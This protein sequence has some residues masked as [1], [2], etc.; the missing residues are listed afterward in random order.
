MIKRRISKEMADHGPEWDEAL[1]D[2]A[3]SIN[4]QQQSSTKY[5]PFFLMFGRE[6]KTLMEVSKCIFSGTERYT[7][8]SMSFMLLKRQL[9][10]HVM[11]IK[12]ELVLK[13][14]GLQTFL[15]S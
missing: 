9:N 15:G 14:W 4:S 3:F 11:V 5:S 6:S 8:T 10:I 13:H 2:V 12:I 7:E 1:H